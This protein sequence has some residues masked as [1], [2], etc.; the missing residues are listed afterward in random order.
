MAKTNRVT[1]LRRN[2][3]SA[4][5]LT[6]LFTNGRGEHYALATAL[7]KTGHC[8]QCYCCAAYSFQQLM[9]RRTRGKANRPQ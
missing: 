9:I 4:W 3:E 2:P 7:G 6:N 1:E 8:G 5:L